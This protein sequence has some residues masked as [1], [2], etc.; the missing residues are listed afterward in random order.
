LASA[1]ITEGGTTTNIEYQYNTDGIRVSKTVDGEETRFLIDANQQEFAQVIEEYSPGGI[2][3][4]VYTHGNDLISQTRDTEKGFYHADSLGSVRLLTDL[5]G[6][7]ANTYL[8]DPYG[9]VINQ[10]EIQQNSYKFTGEQFDRELENYYLRAR[11]YDPVTGRFVS[12]DPFAG[13]LERPLSLN[14]YL[15]TEGN[16]INAIDPSGEVSFLE[17]RVLYTGFAL[18]LLSAVETCAGESAFISIPLSVFKVFRVA[19]V[20]LA[21]VGVGLLVCYLKPSD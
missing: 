9:S 13:F 18:G 5:S 15:Y 4:V 2:I 20:V 10:L 12:R 11:Y 14:D 21:G 19:A 8:Y 6:N 16:P 7:V 17:Y 1:A 3:Q